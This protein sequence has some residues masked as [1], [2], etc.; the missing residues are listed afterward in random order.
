MIFYLYEIKNNINGKIYIGVHK[1][2]DIDDGY[3]G[4]GKVLQ[5]AYEK[6]GVENF[7]KTILE[8]FETTEEMFS[9]E[10]EI[11][12]EEFLKRPDV[13]NLRHGGYGGFDY[14]NK[15][16]LYFAGLSRQKEFSVKG[17]K[18]QKWLR[19]ND[20]EWKNRRDELSRK[21]LEKGRIV[22]QERYPNGTWAGKTHSE[23]SKQKMSQ[24][25][26]GKQTGSEN[27]QFGTMWITNGSEN[28]KIKVTEEIPPGWN[29]G[30][31]C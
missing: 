27:S 3:M 24:A 20:Q 14:I 6:Y 11:V 13:Y 21:G 17:I 18:K 7:T 12:N 30:R 25:K 1:T 31:R 9:R 22:I 16:K 10:K 19:E 5:A 28:K 23:D 8:F 2:S 26:K 15:N 4:S 29:K